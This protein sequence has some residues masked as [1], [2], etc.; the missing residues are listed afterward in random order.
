MAIEWFYQVEGEVVGP[1]S[2]SRLKWLA[3]SG[4][5]SSESLVKKGADGDWV[6][7][8]RFKGFYEE[9]RIAEDSKQ[10]R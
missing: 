7:A 5:I 8:D 1:A 6:Y 2:A 4:D 9:M 3:R 10:Q